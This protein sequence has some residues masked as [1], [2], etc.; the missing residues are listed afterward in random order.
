MNLARRRRDTYEVA[1]AA[2]ISWLP[3]V[4]GSPH[5]IAYSA[6]ALLFMARYAAQSRDGSAL[7]RP[8]RL[9]IAGLGW[10]ALACLAWSW[11]PLFAHL[12]A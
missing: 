7:T 5:R 11:L 10:S 2:G 8:R 1:L 9:L 12:T 4:L 6:F 3:L